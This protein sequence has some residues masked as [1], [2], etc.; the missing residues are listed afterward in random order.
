MAAIIKS[1]EEDLYKLKVIFDK[2]KFICKLLL[3]FSLE[4]LRWKWKN[5]IQVQQRKNSN[6]K[7]N[8]KKR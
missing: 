8:C 5:V 7:W 2:I 3:W 6:E 1:L 4:I